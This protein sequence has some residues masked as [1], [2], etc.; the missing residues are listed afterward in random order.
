MDRTM[1][2]ALVLATWVSPAYADDGASFV[3]GLVIVGAIFYLIPT[4]I[5]FARRHPNR[6]PIAVINIVLGGTG[7]G[8]L[9]SLVWAMSA[10]HRSPT[11]SHGGESGLN[12]FVNDARALPSPAAEVTAP[13]L[14]DLTAR[15]LQLKKLRDEGV[16]DD[17]DFDEFRKPLIDQLRQR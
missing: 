10:V 6:W 9:G 17:R 3:M 2:A 8:W 14:E 15:L 5:A 1:I 7:L 12:L 4:W 13:S 11:G 16:I